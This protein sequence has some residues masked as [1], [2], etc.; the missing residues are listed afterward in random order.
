MDLTREP[1][2][3]TRVWTVPNALS[4]ARLLLLAAFLVALFARHDRLLAAVLLALAGTTDF[5]DG[6]VARRFDQVSELGKVLDPTVDR[7]VLGT[8]IVAMLVY[9]AVPAWLGG[10]VIG[11]ET[12]IALAALALAARGARRIDVRFIGK[13]G[14]FGLMSSFPLLLVGDGPGAA[15][16][17]LTVSGWVLCVPALALSLA[18]IL[19]YVP[20]ARRALAVAKGTPPAEAR[21]D[22]GS[23]R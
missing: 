16:R 23:T 20:D 14:T 15:A 13:A 8:S 21:I 7:I 22:L 6:Y 12:F 11:R 19:A 3:H 17:A 18:A 10:V 2:R 9:G 4:A 5:L 1:G